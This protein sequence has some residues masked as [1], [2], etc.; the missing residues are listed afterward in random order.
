MPRKRGEPRPE[1]PTVTHYH[2]ADGR[3]C[4][5]DTPGAV[6]T[7]IQSETYAV[8]LPDPDTGRM[9]WVSLKTRDIGAAWV[10][11]DRVLKDR[12]KTAAGL[13]SK[14][15]REAVRPIGE[16]L[17]EW[18]AH[19]RATGRTGEAQ[20]EL[21]EARVRNLIE[22]GEWKRLPEITMTTATKALAKI[23]QGQVQ[24]MASGHSGRSNRTRNHYRRHLS[25]FLR[26]C[27]ADGRL[28]RNPMD[29]VGALN[30]EVDPR[31]PRRV[32][33]DVELG[34][35]AAYLEGQW[36]PEPTAGSVE[37]PS[38][39]RR[40]DKMSGK[41]RGLGY[42]IAMATGLRAEELRELGREDF[43]LGARQVT[44]RAAAFSKRRRT[45]VI[46]LPDW[47]VAELAEWFAGDGGCWSGFP[48]NHPGRLLEA[49]LAAC[50]IPYQTPAGYFDFHALRHWYCT[51]AAS[52]PGVSPKTLQAMARHSDPSLTL[53]VYA[54]PVQSEVRRVVDQIPRPGLSGT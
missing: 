16:H 42:R 22:A 14:V 41:Q 28:E 21:L 35:L 43:D 26:W 27:V 25:Q 46:E 37:P 50:G 29:A 8:R 23:Q 17:T 54:K 1:Q 31:H 12:E 49:D 32:P 44:C 48:V 30:V 7:T 9:T 36:R 20:V 15:L 39:G 24:G 6:K 51:F 3:R 11:L 5:K 33:S 47:L 53:R 10:E 4:K 34:T 38:L 40:G 45:T 2:D 13:V 52:C 18:I 19:V